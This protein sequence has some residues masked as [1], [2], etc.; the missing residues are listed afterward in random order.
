[1]EFATTPGP[2]NWSFAKNG[3]LGNGYQPAAVV[4]VSGVPYAKALGMHPPWGDSLRVCYA[5]GK[6]A[7][8]LHGTAAVNDTVLEPTPR[9]RFVVFGDDKLLWRSSALSTRAATE[10]FKIDVSQ[11]DILELRTYTE[12]GS[13][14]QA[15]AVCLDPYVTLQ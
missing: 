5:L 4:R 3:Q 7:K 2:P 12:N 15:H 10:A 6:Q 8:T 14:N 9:I 11:V 13:V 1:M